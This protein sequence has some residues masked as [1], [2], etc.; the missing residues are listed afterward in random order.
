MTRTPRRTLGAIAAVVA[1]LTLAACG[2]ADESDEPTFNDADV[3][4]A[5]MMIPHHQQAVEMVDIVLANPAVNPDVEALA[6]QIRDAQQPEIDLMTSWLEA[7]GAEPMDHGGHMDGLM[8]EDDMEELASA[9]DEVNTLFMTQMI[10]HHEGAVAM[11]EDQLENGLDPA[12][13]ALAEEIIETQNE[14]IELM[15][16]YLGTATDTT[17]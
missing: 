15:G 13:L 6:E 7:W 14:E 8:S 2:G 3:M 1:A 11:A 10:E 4:F 16:S 5:Q 12:A 9:G 17:H